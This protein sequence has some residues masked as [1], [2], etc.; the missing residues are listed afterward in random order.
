MNQNRRSD[1][2]R[3]MN[4]IRRFSALCVLLLTATAGAAATL[5][6]DTVPK[7]QGKALIEELRS[8]GYVVFFRHGITGNEGEKDVAEADIE[9]CT[10][11]RNLS[12]SGRAQ[13][14]AIGE[15]VRREKIPVGDVFASPYCRTMESAR[16]IFG[17]ATRSDA[18]YFAIHVD[19][20]RRLEITDA[21]RRMLA[22]TP[23]PGTNTALISHT[24]N[25][26]EAA[27][28]WPK[29]EGVAHVFRPTSEGDFSY[30][31]VIQPED[32]LP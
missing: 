22:T 5:Q 32:W 4:R 23:K 13:V 9:N 19:K 1:M 6:G 10:I 16:S 31:G 2:V 12:D 3:S 7:L 26:R 24:A 11:Q 8:G 28:I 21:L 17:R 27:D 18:L 15:A 14:A 25:L 29:P 20:D 30:V